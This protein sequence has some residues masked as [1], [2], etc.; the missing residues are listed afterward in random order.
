VERLTPEGLAKL[1][2]EERRLNEAGWLSERQILARENGWEMPFSLEAKRALAQGSNLELSPRQIQARS[3]RSRLAR[4]L[5][6]VK[7]WW[8]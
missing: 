6:A 1:E 2:A 5:A 7:E 3:E 4:A 8:K